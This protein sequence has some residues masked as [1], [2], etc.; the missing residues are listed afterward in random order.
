M[1]LEV[2]PLTYDVSP[3]DI[4]AAMRIQT[5][6][7]DL[8]HFQKE[9]FIFSLVIN[10][11]G[12]DKTLSL[13]LLGL[14]EDQK[15]AMSVA[16]GTRVKF[17]PV[18]L[19]AFDSV[20]EAAAVLQSCR[21]DIQDLMVFSGDYWFA[22]SEYMPKIHRILYGSY[23]RRKS[24]MSRDRHALLTELGIISRPSQEDLE[25]EGFTGASSNY[26][27]VL[28][29]FAQIPIW[30]QYIADS[31][32]GDRQAAVKDLWEV[33]NAQ[34]EID[35]E[36]KNQIV[37]NLEGSL[38]DRETVANQIGAKIGICVRIP[39][40]KEQAAKDA[41]LAR[42]LAD[43]ENAQL[44]Y[45]EANMAR[46]IQD[47]Y[48]SGLREN[49]SKAIAEAEEEVFKIFSDSLERIGEFAEGSKLTNGMRDRIRENLER[50][51]TLAGFGSRGITELIE[52]VA[53]I[54]NDTVNRASSRQKLQ[55]RL[56]EIRTKIDAQVSVVRSGA[57]GHK[58]IAQWMM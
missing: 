28:G 42:N 2:S 13:D 49:L 19:R 20:N 40:L 3:S 16:D 9:T 25:L 54:S 30:K 37:A 35:W 4:A 39:S 1:A 5:R 31:Y 46:Q 43:R 38:P 57:N 50:L 56:T 21:E 27:K 48:M 52:S 36:A 23:T 33:L 6:D 32:E 22:R 11:G 44:A 26:D 7:R 47:E 8:S 18:K 53:A 12:V 34:P 29:V 41:E 15:K 10:K 17:R 45:N 51:E 55:E 24:R 14:D 58:A